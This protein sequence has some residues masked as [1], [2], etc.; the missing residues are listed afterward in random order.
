MRHIKNILRLKY[1]NHLSLREIARSC[2]LPAS[3][4]GLYLQRAEATGLSWPLPADLAEPELVARLM[5]DS[6]PLAASSPG[7]ALPDWPAIH[8]ELRRPNVTLQLLWREYRQ[9][10]PDGYQRSQFCQRYQDWARTLEPVLR[11][12]HEPGQK[13]FVDWAGQTVPIHQA[14]GT[15]SEA[16]LFVAV[17]GA[18]KKIFAAAFPN[19]QLESWIAGHCQAFNFYGGVTRAVV[20]DNTR[21]AVIHPDRY[22]PVLHRTYQEMA[23]H[24]GTV[25]LPAR[26]KKPKDKAPVETAVGITQRQIL[27]AL[28][29]R[30]FFGVG[31]LNQTIRPLL[32]QLNAQPFQK[33]EGSRDRWFEAFEKDKLLPLPA[34][35]FEL[36]TWSQ[37]KVNIDYHVAVDHHF[38]SVPYS[39]IHRQLDVRLSE[40][41]VELFQE[42]QRV[43]AHV[44]SHQRGK[45]TTLEEHRPKAHQ[46]Y[47]EWTPSRLV[48]WARQTGPHCGQLIEQI[49]ADKPHP[50]QGFRS[51]LGVIRLGK[52]VG[53]PRLEAACARALRLGVCSYRSVKSILES[54]LD[55]QTAEPELPLNSP[56]HENLRGQIYYA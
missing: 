29:D 17:L 35:A 15:A 24:Y 1:Q 41:T 56:A 3:T 10:H 18:S 46:R 11:Q 31:E 25:I 30:R 49:L 53:A 21:T 50:E 33:L 19:Q 27:A 22:E 12:V 44:R 5:M 9:A 26:I 34:T 47:L 51:A 8:R 32:G 14:D 28:R 37:A 52:A 2:G 6:D 39:L 42:G 43:A 7:K 16:S 13:L 20:P 4:V 40:R 23:Q 54:G 45:F 38:Y 36:A 55:R 48:Q